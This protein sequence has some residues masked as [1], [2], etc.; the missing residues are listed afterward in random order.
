VVLYEPEVVDEWVVLEVQLAADFHAARL[1]LDAGELDAVFGLIALDAA[2]TFEEI[3]MPP[4]AAILAVGAELH[5]NLF[6]L[7]DQLFDLGVHGLE[8]RAGPPFSRL[9]RFL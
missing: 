7:L 3:E 2:E 5:A 6:L 8:L 1:G 9:A 4:G